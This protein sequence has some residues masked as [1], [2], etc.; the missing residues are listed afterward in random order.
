MRTNLP[1]TGVERHL[2]EGQ[3][4][5]S[6]SDLR[7][8][9]TYVNR[10]LLEITGFTEAEL[11]GQPHNILR[12]PDMPVEA[13]KDF[14]ATLKAG[15][16]WVGLVKNRC[17]NGDHYWVMANASPILQNGTV[18]GYMSVR[19]R[20]DRRLV[21][22]ADQF[23]KAL[24]NNETK[25]Q[26]VEGR[27]IPVGIK[28]FVFRLNEMSVKTR[29][30]LCML[31]IVC[32]GIILGGLGLYSAYEGEQSLDDVVNQRMA[33]NAVLDEVSAEYAVN[34]V[35][36]INKA[37]AGRIAS[38]Q[39]IAAIEEAQQKI[40][41]DWKKLQ[42]FKH[43][44]DVLKLIQETEGMMRPV[45]SELDRVKLRL[46]AT[47]D[48]PTGQLNDFD[49]M[50]YDAIDPLTNQ[51]ELIKDAKQKTALQDLAEVRETQT[52]LMYWILAIL[53]LGAILIAALLMRTFRLI[54]QPL[55]RMRKQ[56]NEIAQG[57]YS[58][59]VTRDGAQEI[60]EVC[61]TFKSMFIKLRF[62]MADSQRA[63]DEAKRIGFALDN[64]S[65]AVTVSNEDNNLIYTNK[66][67]R[68]QLERVFKSSA[69][70]ES[71]FGHPIADSVDSKPIRDII[72]GRLE[73]P[74]SAEDRVGDR[75]IRLATTPVI[76]DRG[77]YL[78]RVC[79][80]Q[81][82]TA[83]VA[84]E[85]EVSD[86]VN[87]AAEGDFTSRISVV[88]KDG[89][90]ETLAVGLNQLIEGV[91]NGLQDVVRVLNA[92]AKGD[93]S[94][95]IEREYR[96]TLEQMKNDANMTVIQLKSIVSSITEATDA[97]NSAAK[98]IASGNADLSRRTEQQAASLE[99][100]ASSTEEL[101]NTVKNNADN[102]NRAM[103]LARTSMEVADRG[104]RVV[105]E[106]VQTMG[107]I[108]QSSSKIAEIINVI[109]GIAFQTNILALNAAVEAARAGEQGRGFAVVAGEVRNLAQRS[110]SA[111]KEIKGLISESVG[112]VSNGY[113][114]V[115]SAGQTMGEIVSSTQ[116][117]AQIMSEISSASE[118]QRTGIM[119]LN[120]AITSMDET[121]Q[122]NA[123]LVEQAAAAAQSLED[124]SMNL[125]QAVGAFS[126]DGRSG[127]GG[128][129]AR[130]PIRGAGMDG[131]A[132][133]RAA[134]TASRKRAPIS[135]RPDDEWE[136]F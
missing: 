63:A 130:M 4:I 64:V 36:T 119:Q 131:P 103:Q 52:W 86:L 30:G 25:N 69:A 78:G 42:T 24:R 85:R 90:F 12:H 100:T 46:Q 94:Q 116:N 83:E 7:G 17:K 39:A 126:V 23:Y 120:Q 2:D 98:E 102:A 110:A 127:G 118:E 50:L 13:F 72:S 107:D 108:Q 111:A 35:D 6:K 20:P 32:T 57:N 105:S 65:T 109:D 76:D 11:M 77:V 133:M 19:S 51:I 48:N 62:D 38:N 99:E 9:I 97:I 95:S 3:Y 37:N 125:T 134:A 29:L 129:P 66:A 5:L 122:Q 31:L 79:Q 128:R 70:V 22:Q 56:M 101:T 60:G 1:V 117:V 136:E 71:M 93:L 80:W 41:E 10:T 121:T 40:S 54:T 84:V 91:D 104:G 47:P 92:L 123:A 16:S 113:K 58:L 112:K 73:R 45:N 14:W 68:A 106:V 33:A 61:D 75:V 55:E 15:K 18:V 67:G 27:E 81:D 114:L 87:A 43:S 21:D 82:R 132:R 49:G 124:Q 59:M 74:M 115:E 26:L 96:G 53:A 8:N 89:F 135:T 88:G 28:G 44:S 34:I